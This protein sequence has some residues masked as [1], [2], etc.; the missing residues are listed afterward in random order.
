MR[1]RPE[2][3]DAEQHQG[4]PADPAGHRGPADQ[5]GEAAC[6]AADHDV[7]RAAALE[8]QRVDEHVETDRRVSERGGQPVRPEPEQQRRGH[9]EQDPGRQRLA[10]PHRG[11]AARAAA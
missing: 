4:W 11:L 6:R 7:R 8:P 5:D 9:A 3:H 10:G 2:E 1:R